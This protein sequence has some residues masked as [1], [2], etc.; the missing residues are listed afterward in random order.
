MAKLPKKIQDIVD[1]KQSYIDANRSKL[2]A[3]VIKMQ[4]QLLQSFIENILP[5]LETKDGQILNTP[6]NLKL[7]E[8]LDSLYTEFNN[9]TQ[10]KVVKSLGESLVNLNKFNN[11]YFSEI[12][13]NETTK[14]K[15]DAIVSKTDKLISARIG[16]TPEGEVNTGGFLDSFVTDRTLLTDLKKSIIQN[17]TGQQSLADFKKS[18]KEKIVGSDQVTGGFERYYRQYAYDVYQEYDRAYGKQMAD[19]FG[20]NYALYQGG[21][22]GD[23]RDF[24][25]DHENHVYTREEVANFGKWTYAKAEHITTF[26][27]P[28]SQTGVPSYIE[29]FPNYDPATNCGGFNCRHQLTWIT[30]AA[31]IR[32]RPELAIR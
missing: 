16:I 20:L 28:G 30:K 19:E 25:R 6:K 22:I 14:K 4:E 5:E 24:C 2:E 15:F 7:I 29:N 13:L 23:S 11:D 21:L 17:I 10:T 32:I 27:D 18:I 9:T 31:A 3:S 12:T 8:K 26:K 1:K